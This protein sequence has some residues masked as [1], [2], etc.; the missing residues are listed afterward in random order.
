M[1]VQLQTVPQIVRQLDKP[2]SVEPRCHGTGL[3]RDSGVV[4]SELDLFYVC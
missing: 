3:Q 1:G 4:L 2:Q